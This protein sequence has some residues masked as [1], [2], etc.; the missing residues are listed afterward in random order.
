[1]QTVVY[2]PLLLA[3]PGSGNHDQLEESPATEEDV[4]QDYYQQALLS[5]GLQRIDCWTY[6][7]Q[8]WDERLGILKVSLLV[9]PR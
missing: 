6:I 8:D 1:M 4:L 7:L 5:D 2:P 9:A 3:A